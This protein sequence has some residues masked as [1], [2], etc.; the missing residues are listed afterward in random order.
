MFRSSKLRDAVRR[1]R[2]L[3][4]DH[5]TPVLATIAFGWLIT[6]GMRFVVPAVLPS[7]KSDLLIGNTVAG[8]AVSLLWLMYAVMQFPSGI[9]I[10][11][12]GERIVLILSML[13]GGAG[14]LLFTFSPGLVTFFVACTLFGLGTGLFGTPR[15]TVLSKVY[16]E[17]DGTALGITF[18]AGN[19]GAAILPVCAGVISLYLGWRASFGVVVP[20]FALVG[21]GMVRTLPEGSTTSAVDKSSIHASRRLKTGLIRRPV[22]LAGGAITIV[23]FSFQGLTAFLPIYLITIK[24]LNQN[25]AG[26]LYGLFF[27][28]GAVVQPLAGYVG[29]RYGNRNA[30]VAITG[31]YTLGLFALPFAGR[32]EHLIVLVVV[33]GTRSGIGPINNSYLVASLPDDIRGSGYGLLRTTY[34]VIASTGSLVVGALS[35]AGWFDQAFVF[36]AVLTAIATGFYVILPERG[37]VEA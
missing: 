26:S 15:V 28:A 2:G 31:V 29:D 1:G 8:F 5:R 11:R 36:L 19:V 13:V 6:Q 30:L 20:L 33:L 10:D 9:L 25:I 7:V 32:L 21:L 23:V 17:N 16:S 4:Y 35:E 34:L 22:L 18:A 37:V 3:L 27:T 12:I 14:L 24:G